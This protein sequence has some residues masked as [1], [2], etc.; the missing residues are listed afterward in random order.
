MICDERCE[1]GGIVHP[2]LH[3][4]MSRAYDWYLNSIIKKEALANPVFLI[5][6]VDSVT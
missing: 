1:E 5:T 6:A 3:L 2:C 4:L